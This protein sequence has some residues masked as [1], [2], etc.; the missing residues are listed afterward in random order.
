MST[1]APDRSLL[2]VQNRFQ[3]IVPQLKVQVGFFTQVQGLAAQVDT[4]EYAEG[5]RNDFVYKIPSRI[6]H[7]ILTLKRGVTDESSLLS[8]LEQTVV[9]AKLSEITL[10]LRRPDDSVL[11]SWSFAAAYPVKWT[12]PDLNAGGAEVMSESL[13]IAHQGVKIVEVP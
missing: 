1:D 10:N 7:P 13:E 11:R 4:I 12:G 5:G 2:F 9:E 6:K 3:L 8:W